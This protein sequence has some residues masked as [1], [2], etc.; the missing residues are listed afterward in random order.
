MDFCAQ[1][2]NDL[3]Q[4][5]RVNFTGFGKIMKKHDRHTGLIG[6]PWFMLRLKEQPFHTNSRQFSRLLIKFSDACSACRKAL[7][8]HEQSVDVEEGGFQGFQ[9][10]T[11]KYWVKLSD[12][13]AVKTF[14]ARHLPVYIYTS[15]FGRSLKEED[16]TDAA[17]ISSCYY[18]NPDSF[19]CYQSRIRKD[20][21]AIAIRFRVYENSKEVFV[22]RKTHHQNWVMEN[23][24]KERFDLNESDVYDFVRGNYTVEDYNSHLQQRGKSAAEREAACKLFESVHEQIS[25]LSL[26]PSV[27]TVYRRTAFQIA[28]D[29]RVRISLD[30]DLTMVKELQKFTKE[31]PRWK[32]DPASVPERDIHE[33]PYAILEVKLQTHKG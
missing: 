26:R 17:L 6:M 11:T 28:G 13:M 30:T 9:R 14:I 24:I 12:V 7:G 4:Y 33:F 2:L 5:T 21:G 31:P 16:K 19:I 10:D 20:E 23:S 25:E 32:R 29:A 3:A 18:D 27:T 22:E 1:S 15:D 8:A